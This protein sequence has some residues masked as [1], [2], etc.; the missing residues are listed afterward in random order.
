MMM[1]P[2]RSNNNMLKTLLFFSLG[3]FLLCSVNPDTGF[4]K[5]IKV[6][7][8]KVKKK[9][10]DIKEVTSAGGIKAWLVEDHSVPVISLNFSFLNSGSKN[11]PAEKQGLARLA[12]NTMD[13][14]A[15]DLDSQSFQKELQNLSISFGFS[16]GRDHFNG[17]LKTLTRNKDRAFTLM[18]L[19]LTKP[20]F[21][22]EPLQRM[23]AANQSRIR[24]SMPEPD[25]IAARIQNDRI[26]EGHP[27]ALN[28]G[29][30]LSSLEKITSEDLKNFHKSLGKNTLRISVAGD[31]S[32]S[33]L[34]K[35]LDDVFG[36][37]PKVSD[38]T[39]EKRFSL[40]NMGKTY[41]F[42]KDIPQTI[43]EI[44]QHGIRRKDE[45]YYS[46]QVM[47]FILGSSGFGSRLTEEIREKRGLTYG[48]YS[49]F[50]E[51]ED[52]AVFQVSTST[53]NTKV[54]DVISLI[55]AEWEKMKN[56]DVTAKELSE[57]KSYI[58]GSLPLS[59]TSTD[60]ICGLLQSL[61]LDDLPLDYLDQRTEKINAVTVSDV[62]KAAQA[63]LNVQE[64]TTILVG[65]P[66]NIT[67]AVA[68]ESLPNV[69]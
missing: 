22:Q 25:W 62:R 58:I 65:N 49:Y 43:I 1:T 8:A 51:Y 68:I 66:S 28:S 27:Y 52:T 30:T 10:L 13:E 50:Q 11:D 2:V 38:K 35:I 31:I 54:I 64:F 47:N 9:F 37:L 44:S 56:T 6:A 16:A 69:E 23:L 60:S 4:A 61:Q 32:V 26:F 7:E 63:I 55:S 21:D 33:E 5:E 59:L 34:R 40:A 36:A 24:G 45:N 14:G 41:L 12:S 19:A 20:R 15:G 48:I 29:G 42:K 3:V 39:E 46:A 53:E 57:A 18:R 67:N 17:S